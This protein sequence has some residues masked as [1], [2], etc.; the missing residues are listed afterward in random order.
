MRFVYAASPKGIRPTAQGCRVA[1]L[2]W[3]RQ[4]MDTNPKGVAPNATRRSQSGRNPFGVDTPF[5]DIPRVAAQRG[6]PGLLDG[7]PLGFIRRCFALQANLLKRTVL[8]IL[9]VTGSVNTHCD[10]AFRDA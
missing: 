9:P 7:I 4:R 2:P 1:R 10:C 3:V 6:N 8:G 5:V